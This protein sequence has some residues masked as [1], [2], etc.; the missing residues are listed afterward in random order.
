MI[1]K[2]ILAFAVLALAVASAETYKVTLFQPTL[3]QGKELKPGDYRINLQDSKVII[4]AG[5]ESV[6]TTVKVENSDTKFASTSVRYA[7]RRRQV[8]HSGNSSRRHENQVGFQSVIFRYLHPA[9]VKA[10][11]GL[12]LKPHAPGAQCNGSRRGTW[13]CRPGV[14]NGRPAGSGGSS[15]ARTGGSRL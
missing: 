7:Y 14:R 6:E 1:K 8:L 10:P 5:K 3:V 13:R 15:S 11:A 12:P 2:L 9:G 4:A